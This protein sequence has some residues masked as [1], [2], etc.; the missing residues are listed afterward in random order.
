MSQT[1]FRSFLMLTAF[2]RKCGRVV[3]AACSPHR[4]T[5]PR[6]FIVHP[7]S[8]TT[9]G[10]NIIDL[11]GDDE[12]NTMSSFG[13]FR[14]PALGGGEIVRVCNPCVPDPNYS[15]PPPY[16]PTANLPQRYS[17]YHPPSTRS[18]YFPN[19]ASVGPSQSVRLHRPSH[20]MND[21]TQTLGRERSQTRRARDPFSDRRV[22]FHHSTRVADLW[23]PPPQPYEPHRQSPA[24]AQQLP[25]L[26]PGAHSPHHSFPSR[27][28]PENSELDSGPAYHHG[29]RRPGHLMSAAQ[30]MQPA[31]STRLIAEEDE[32]PICLNELPPKG[33][34]GDTAAREQHVTDC[35][36][37]HS[38]SPPPPTTNQT[39]TSL[40]SQ[41]TRGMSTASANVGEGN[42]E[43]ASNRVSLSRLTMYPYVA[44]E[45]D[46]VGEDGEEAECVI[47]LVEFEAGDH[48]GRLACWCKFHEVCFPFYLSFLRCGCVVFGQKACVLVV[49]TRL[50]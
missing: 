24:H 9:A 37:A 26:P 21:G 7:P 23:P 6:Q 16:T 46:C 11:T 43:G 32:C 49:G 25:P 4:I 31:P 47:C 50:D 18:N 17:S 22:S 12:N 33:P 3:C 19:N 5:I 20:S 44:T 30:S 39:S 8:D 36:A 35:I 38:S 13:P 41:R 2:S 29:T 40:P 34:N 14:N 28:Q 48:L 10:A 27:P 15:P 42:G 45:K 1:C